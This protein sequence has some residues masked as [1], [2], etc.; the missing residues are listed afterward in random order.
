MNTLKSK[1]LLF[2]L[3]MTLIFFTIFTLNVHA[4]EIN[5]AVSPSKV[6]NMVI[7]PGKSETVKFKVGNRSVFPANQEEKNDLYEIVV[8]VDAQ[9]VGSDG[10]PVK[11]DGIVKISN[12][13][14]KAKP[15]KKASETSV[16][17]DIPRDFEKNSY[18]VD[19][20]F[21]R[22]PI[23]G[24]EDT[25]N[26]SAITSIKVPIYMGV[27]KPSE[28]A[29]LKTDYDVKDFNIDLG[30][31]STV[32]KYALN[33]L[34]ELITLNPFKV[35]DVFSSIDE[36]DVYVVNKNGKV[37]VDVL[38]G[39]Y[40]EMRNA[41]TYTDKTTEN[42]YIKIRDIDE[43]KEVSNIFFEDKLVKFALSDGTNINISCH[44]KVRDNIRNQINNLIKEH[45]LSKPR[46]RFFLDNLMVPSNKNFNIL[47]YKANM[48]I[49]NTG[50]KENFI[51][52]NLYLKKDSTY[53]VG[54]QKVELLTIMK[55]ETV[56][57]SMPLDI[58]SEITSGSYSLLGEFIDIKNNI[59]TENFT[60]AVD[61]ELDK[62][63]FM[64]TLGLYILAIALIILIIYI[65]YIILKG[66]K[67]VV[68]YIPKDDTLYRE[69]VKNEENF[70]KYS[71]LF[72]LDEID[73]L[74]NLIRIFK[75]DVILRNKPSMKKYKPSAVLCSEDV[76]QIIDSN[77]IIIEDEEETIW[78]KVRFKKI[79]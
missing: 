64:L 40:T 38:S 55:G 23:K 56:D 61:L 58:S 47:D 72:E 7:E 33:N 28:Y 67:G 73:D 60:F 32:F 4:D 6:V 42:K 75:I 76:V 52:A 69:L 46:L 37:T 45:N 12:P 14:L 59:K 71:K 9:I 70:E 22:K 3:T 77:V 17:I 35:Y 24:V 78:L 26:T 16:T 65:I 51:S 49:E 29:K 30:E 74:D 2:T 25:T 63:I 66:K 18:R 39:I 31:T 20:I 79:K 54:R 44:N 34:K 8:M 19:I 10:L 27:G 62:T 50:E 41:V 11:N 68:G 5:F 48:K 21:T 1:Y 13:I 15:N 36:K 53:E 43:N 57:L